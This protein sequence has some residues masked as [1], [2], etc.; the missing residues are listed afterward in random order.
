MHLV[1]WSILIILCLIALYTDIK[2][3][4]IP[5]K[6]NI[7]FTL[8]GIFA[9]SIVFG[10]SGITS[11]ILGSL[12]PLLLLPLYIIR[13]IGAGDIKLF[14]AIGSIS[15]V[16]NMYLI[17]PISFLFA[18]GYCAFR[19]FVNKFD[20]N[21]FENIKIIR[22]FI[23]SGY[24]IEFNNKKLTAFR[25]VPYILLGVITVFIQNVILN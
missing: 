11:S 24:Q 2:Y 14:I 25:F 9:N 20:I 4:K 10:I 17:L 19:I 5:N 16:Q 15:G 13:G 7:T 8:L 21:L 1:F 23:L 3:F 6:V 18:G 22:I 12:L